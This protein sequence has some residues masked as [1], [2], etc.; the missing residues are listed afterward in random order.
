[1]K[2]FFKII[3]VGLLIVVVMSFFGFLITSIDFASLNFWGVKYENTR[4]KIFEETKAF[5]ESKSQDLS[6]Y[7]LEYMS[8]DQTKKDAIKAVIQVQFAD[9][10]S[11]KIKSYELQQ[12]LINTRGF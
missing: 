11:S 6:K 1:M 8:G 12:F 4:T 5:N 10:D 2:D 9:Y 3:G 7:Y